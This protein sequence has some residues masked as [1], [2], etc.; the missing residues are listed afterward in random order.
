MSAPSIKPIKVAEH[1]CSQSKYTHVA[2][3]PT[4]S[5]ILAPSGGG[6]TVLLQNLVLDVY[7]NCFSR[8]YVFSPSINVDMTWN[9]VKQ[10]L[11]Q[12]LGQ[13]DSREKY[14]FDHYD[15]AELQS[16]IDTQ[17]KVVEFMKHN[18]MKTIYQ[19]LIII[20]DFADSP[21]FTRAS[22]I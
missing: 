11:E 4:R 8:I 21:D 2:T 20:D 22:N 9:P 10:Y 16:I 15:P 12:G 7:L 18:K 1:H 14:L 19:I 6:K 17:Y 5:M 3:L 13:D